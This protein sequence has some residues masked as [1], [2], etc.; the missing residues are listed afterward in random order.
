MNPTVKYRYAKKKIE[1]CKATLKA[2]KSPRLTR[3]KVVVDNR[4]SDLVEVLQGVNNLHDD[5]AALFLR[6]EFVLLQVE[7]QVVPL[8]VL[9]H[10]AKPAPE[11]DHQHQ[12]LQ[13]NGINEPTKQNKSSA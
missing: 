2:E 10:C 9:Q 1:T 7:V 6:H 12:R 3:F 11:K 4:R 8:A 5:G 13:L